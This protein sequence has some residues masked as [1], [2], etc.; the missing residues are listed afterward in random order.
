MKDPQCIAFLQWALPR[1]Q[2]RW[3]GYR[4]VRRQVCKRVDRRIQALGLASVESYRARLEA[5]P[6]EWAVLDDLTSITISRFFRER[7]VFTYLCETAL[8]ELH[9]LVAP[10]PVRIWSAG[11]AAGEEAYTLAIAAQQQ[12]IPVR[13]VATD[14]DEHQLQRAREAR[15]SAGCL[16]DLPERW[17]MSAFEQRGDEFVLRD[18]LRANVELLRQDI[19]RD[20][21]A[22][23]FHLILCRYLAFTYF[24]AQLQRKIAERLLM[25]TIPNGFLV[26]GKHESWPFDVSGLVETQPGL[27]VY[28]KL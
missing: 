6:A 21:P 10:E 11:C 16:K 9:A 15:Y 1:L 8:P 14:W 7:D 17:W 27:R 5:D 2:L 19:R 28:R 12:R 13:I 25:R 3:P 22:G 24:D 20:M 4:K 26:L 23:P 18:E